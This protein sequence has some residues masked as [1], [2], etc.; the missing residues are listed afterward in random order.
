[1]SFWLLLNYIIK[2]KGFCLILVLISAHLISSL[3]DLLQDQPVNS[4]LLTHPLLPTP[5]SCKCIFVTHFSLVNLYFSFIWN[6]SWHNFLSSS[7]E[8]EKKNP[9]C[10]SYCWGLIYNVVKYHKAAVLGSTRMHAANAI[11]SV[12]IWIFNTLSMAQMFKHTATH[13][14]VMTQR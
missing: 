10:I 6:G 8:R 1:M 7:H 3:S 14:L 11:S 5:K 12:Y 4:K 2:E 9:L 13:R